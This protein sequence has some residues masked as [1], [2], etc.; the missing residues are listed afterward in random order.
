MKRMKNYF[1]TI[2]LLLGILLTL[3]NCEENE[4]L[5]DVK[6]E[7]SK[8][9]LTVINKNDFTDNYKL[10]QNLNKFESKKTSLKSKKVYNSIYNF[11]I[12]TNSVTYIE[13]DNL[14]S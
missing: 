4:S 14:H 8:I 9:K 11:T 2:I 10:I 7:K 13:K 3:S 5:I 6:N 12:N 1:K